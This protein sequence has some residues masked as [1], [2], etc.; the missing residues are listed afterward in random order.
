MLEMHVRFVPPLQSGKQ[1][2]VGISGRVQN[3][4]KGGLCILTSEPMKRSDL[5][6]CEI[7][8]ADGV[9]GVPTLMQVRWTKEQNL[10]LKS[11]VSGLQFLI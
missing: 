8:A 11:Y 6:R 3:V 2:G 4:S 10:R 5:L 9:I 7:P 1:T